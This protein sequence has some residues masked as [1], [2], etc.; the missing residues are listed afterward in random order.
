MN[1][2]EKPVQD[3][4]IPDDTTDYS[5]Q[6][7]V[8]WLPY[9]TCSAGPRKDD[10]PLGEDAAGAAAG[11]DASAIWVADGT[12]NGPTLWQF[13]ARTLAQTLGQQ[14]V[15]NFLQ[16]QQELKDSFYRQ[17]WLLNNIDEVIDSVEAQWNRELSKRLE[18][19]DN[20]QILD[21]LFQNNSTKKPFYI[22]F[23]ATAAFGMVLHNGAV[24][25]LTIGDCQAVVADGLGHVHRAEPS[26]TRH[27]LR[28]Q[29]DR[30]QDHYNFR[31]ITS[32]EDW[33]TTAWMNAQMVIL[34]TD[35]T[36]E[37][38][39]DLIATAMIREPDHTASNLAHITQILTRFPAATDDDKA[40][41]MLYRQLI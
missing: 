40:V 14:F 3:D 21:E 15:I 10:T 23:S 11:V 41:A 18:R 29:Y 4:R 30:E 20:K 6:H 16:S 33:S 28:L 27:Y 38:M 25:T 26:S 31:T 36:S 24:Q 8:T 5:E 32:P 7:V 39:R 34:A 37:R 12:S 9:V 19:S 1:S 17:D 22:D 2:S 13:C 35:G